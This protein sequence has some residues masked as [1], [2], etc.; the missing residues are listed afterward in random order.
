M[1]ELMPWKEEYRVGFD[2]IDA[3][4]IRLVAQINKLGAAMQEGRGKEVLLPVL[5]ELIEYTKTHFSFEEQQMLQQNYPERADHLAKHVD[6]VKQVMKF[7]DDVMSGQIVMSVMVMQ[8]LKD[9]LIKH[10]MQTDKRLGAF[11]ATR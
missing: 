3:Q 9:W 4:H 10:I 6:L 1:K 7:Y 5:E 8:F 2:P 11:L